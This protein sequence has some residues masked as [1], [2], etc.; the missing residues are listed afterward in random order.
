MDLGQTSCMLPQLRCRNVHAAPVP[1]AMQIDTSNLGPDGVYD[2]YAM[3]SG[4]SIFGAGICCGFANL[5]CG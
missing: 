5:V 4:F 3:Y 1:F 2:K